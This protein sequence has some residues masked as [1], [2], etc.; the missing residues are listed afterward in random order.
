MELKVETNVGIYVVEV[1][2]GDLQVRMIEKLRNTANPDEEGVTG[3]YLRFPG[4]KWHGKK[5][6]LSPQW[7]MILYKT[8]DPQVVGDI[9][10]VV[11]KVKKITSS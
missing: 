8:E 3:E 1:V 9:A 4:D 2:D 5:L 11:G 6:V 7:E 10:V